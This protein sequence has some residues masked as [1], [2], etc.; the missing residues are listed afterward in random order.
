[1]K[2]HYLIIA[3]AMALAAV[4]C[5]RTETSIETINDEQSYE[6]SIGLDCPL[7][8]AT[9]I[10]ASN[11]SKISNVQL[12]V[13]T[14]AG[15]LESYDKSSDGNRTLSV[16]SGDHEFY[17]LVNAPDVSASDKSSLLAAAS[18]LSDN[19]I[20]NF[21]M[22]G[23][24]SANI[25]ANANITINVK[26]I[27]AKVTVDKINRK[28]VS[29]SQGAVSMSIDAIYLTNVAGDTDYA[30]ETAPSTWYNKMGYSASAV[31]ALLYDGGINSALADNAAYS[32]SHSFYPYP[33]PTEANKDGGEWSPRHTKL[34]IKTTYGEAT[35]YYPIVLPILERNK[36]YT[37]TDLILTRPGSDDEDVPV[38][39]AD[40]TFNITVVDWETG[41]STTETI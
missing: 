14:S 17:A 23:S 41:S 12:Y 11:E 6:I 36:T 35:K 34:V 3:T 18:A 30:V 13:F 21:V 27:V 22:V 28:F 29:A 2:K 4:S 20:A 1:M 25:T 8:K 33:N 38:S 10:V 15:A 37:I 39:A 32:T 16:T 26:R 5:S 9:S 40:C 24:T 7:T 31:D 19:G